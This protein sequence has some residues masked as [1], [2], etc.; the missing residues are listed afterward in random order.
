MGAD[1]YS[2][3]GVGKDADADALK[4]AYRKAA[5]KWH[6]DKNQGQRELAEKKF[7]EIA[8]AYD[9]LSDPN[10][11]EVYD[12]YGEAGLKRG[13]GGPSGFGGGMPPGVN[14]EELF[15]Q[16]FGGAGGMP[17]GFHFGGMPGGV[18]I[19]GGN[20]DLSDII[21]Q[22]F[23]GAAMGGQPGGARRAVKERKVV[24]SLEELYCGARKVESVDGR[25]FTIDVQP[26]WKAGTKIGFD[27]AGVR[28][29]VA[30]QDHAV[31]S[32]IGNDLTCVCYCGPLELL[33]RGS[34]H[35]IKTLDRRRVTVHVP[36]LSLSARVSGEGM[37]Y[38][39]K[40]ALGQVG[41]RT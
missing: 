21:G 28:F 31:F 39:E 30:Q 38:K 6:P 33:A 40:D 11:K 35:E 27:D 32:R 13:G 2:L 25:S 5:M 12:R 3:L 22:M 15:R 14:P 37:P 36:A 4:K 23:G 26:G 20:V 7:K 34:R 17:G 41:E 16:M 10:K 18:N 24:C 9:V 8:E 1:Y 29:E 19:N